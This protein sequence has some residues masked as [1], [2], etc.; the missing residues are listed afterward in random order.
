MTIGFTAKINAKSEV[1]DT[2]TT[3]TTA[4]A[5][6][7]TDINYWLGK[8]NFS[9][10]ISSKRESKAAQVSAYSV[11]YTMD[12][13]VHATNSDM[14]KG[15]QTVLGILTESIIDKDTNKPA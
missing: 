14:P 7:S 13:N 1:N 6:A 4:N 2:N 9:A 12:I 8:A 15:L 11:E 3:T 5:Q 10:G